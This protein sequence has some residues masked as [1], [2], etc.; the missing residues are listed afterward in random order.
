MPRLVGWFCF[1]S[2]RQRGHLEMAPPFTVPCEG[3]EA[4]FLNRRNIANRYKVNNDIFLAFLLSV[5]VHAGIK[6]T[7][8][9]FIEKK[10]HLA[11]SNVSIQYSDE[12]ILRETE[13]KKN[14]SNHILFNIEVLGDGIINI[15]CLLKHFMDLV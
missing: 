3:R 15:Y 9:L 14:T 11:H 1:T 5:R 12:P 10:V 6:I 8:C 4:L 2:H 7:H 13:K